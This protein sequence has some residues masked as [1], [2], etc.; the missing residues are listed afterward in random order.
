MQCE[1]EAVCVCFLSLF[2]TEAKH[3]YYSFV[4]HG[5]YTLDWIGLGRIAS[6]LHGT[7]VFN[8]IFKRALWGFVSI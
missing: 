3:W 2:P 4:W 5:M 6:E 8:K 7:W 1:E